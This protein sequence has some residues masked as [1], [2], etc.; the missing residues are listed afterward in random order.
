MSSRFV[1]PAAILLLCASAVPAQTPAADRPTF[2]SGV[3]LVRFDVRVVDGNGRPITDLRPEEIEVYEDGKLLPVVLF[4]RVTEPAGTYVDEAMRAVSA[5]VSSNEAFPRGHLYILI[6][7]QQHIT[8]GN[9]QRARIAAEQFLRTRLRPSDRVALYAIPGPGPQI[10][11]TGDKLRVIK[12]LPAIRGSYQR[13]VSTPLGVMNLFEAHRIVQGDEKLITE[14]ISRMAAE[15]VGDVS[16]R[17]V[18]SGTTGAGAALANEDQ[19]VSVRLVRESARTVV[20]QSDSD[21]RQFLQRLTDVIAGFRDIEGRKTVVLFSEGF[22]QDN[23]IREL[24]TVAAAA[25]QSYCV[26]YSFDLN[27]RTMD[28]SEAYAAETSLA[29]EIQARIAPMGTLAVETDGSLVIDAGSRTDKVLDLLADQ[30]RDYY[31]VGFTPSEEARTS[32]G[33]Y[34]RVTLKVKRP[35]AT[36]SA[37]TGYALPRETV[38]TDKR[39]AINNVLGAPF[40]QQGLKVDYTTYIMK[41]PESGRHRVVLSL[42]ADLPV[43]A[44]PG[45]TADVVFVARDVRDGRVVASGT[46]TIAL[47]ANPRPGAA[48][49]SSAWRVQFSVPPGSY[50]M[51]TVVREP[52]GL[53]GSADR[54][55]DVRPLDGPEIGVSDLV[56]STPLSALPVRPRAYTADGLSGVIE[57]YARTSVQM[58]GLE[59]VVELRK[60]G[61]EGSVKSIPAELHEAAEDGAGSNR[62]ARFHLPLEGVEPGD[63]IAHAIVK[64]RGEIV[65]DRTRQVEVLAGSGVLANNA[66]PGL[67]VERVSPAEVVRGELGR[68]YVELLFQRA[69]GTPAEEAARRALE[70]RWELVELQL[71]RPS[72]RDGVAVPALRGL[73]LF[74]R[75]EFA[76]AAAALALALEAEPA[77]ALTAFF[78][79]WA[80]EGAGDSKDAISAWRNA[81]HLDPKMVSAHIALADAYMRLS[82]PALALQSIRA[83]LAAMPDSIELRERLTRLEKH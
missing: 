39:N 15:S 38:I 12:E 34:R 25:A 24:E 10:G 2:K 21:S 69:K 36:L 55:L 6:F 62:R 65:A 30:A 43:R 44:K 58:D 76:G 1:L 8:P 73:A 41:S 3:D 37:R 5:E 70:Q 28:I 16:G 18:S 66:E 53:A 77:N 13:L 20:N 19:S 23:L 47:P 27:P 46:D 48:M 33:K 40:V 54:R 14:A 57:T 81:A 31:L 59:V 45:D 61:Q 26:F 64:A 11:F 63:Y 29:T 71:Q 82:Q 50:L 32:R 80:R 4:Q 74:A 7:D 79:G 51:R 56:I 60:P 49:G 35:G 78:L 68:R 83:G 75:E 52:G 22:F 72:A 9:E 17:T 67:T 42:S